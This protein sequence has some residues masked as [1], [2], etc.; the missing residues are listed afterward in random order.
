ME[1]TQISL[2]ACGRSSI[3]DT[4]KTLLHIKKEVLKLTTS[5]CV[6]CS[7]F[8]AEWKSSSPFSM[9]LLNDRWKAIRAA[10]YKHLNPVLSFSP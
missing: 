4:T 8:I 3:A 6:P 2:V 5:V 1:L 10:K 7:F 9:S